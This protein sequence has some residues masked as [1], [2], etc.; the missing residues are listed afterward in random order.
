[1]A[2]RIPEPLTRSSSLT[3]VVQLLAFAVAWIAVA[4]FAAF[5]LSADP[6]ITAIVSG[7]ATLLFVGVLGAFV[8]SR[9]RGFSEAIREG[10]ALLARGHSLAARQKFE[11]LLGRARWQLAARASARWHL[12]LAHLT[13]GNFTHALAE[14]DLLE[15][16]P[17]RRAF[18]S[19]YEDVPAMVALC[20]ALQGWLDETEGALREHRRRCG[21]RSTDLGLP[22]WAVAACR[23][24]RPGEVAEGLG[25]NWGTL[26]ASHP[27]HALRILRVVRAYAADRSGSDSAAPL[28]GADPSFAT[29]WAR[30]WNDLS[31]WIASFSSRSSRAL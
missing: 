26:E 10:E 17:F 14:F 15:R 30:Q 5:L 21:D 3:A 24:G 7:S 18:P 25:L 28:E 27:E 4:S 13:E 31:V 29:G 19:I 20:F 22:A 11:S 6:F 2:R 9:P 8:F 23:Q 12:A 16:Q 1:M